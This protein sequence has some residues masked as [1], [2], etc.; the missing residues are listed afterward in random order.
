M[1]GAN[2]CN[3]S[4]RLQKQVDKKNRTRRNSS[5]GFL[6]KEFVSRAGEVEVELNIA[7][8]R[9]GFRTRHESKHDGAFVSK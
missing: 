7:I 6:F 3:A 8:V 2:E 1:C 9:A 4:Y 5:L